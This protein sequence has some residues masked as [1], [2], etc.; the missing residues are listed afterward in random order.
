MDFREIG[1]EIVDLVHLVQDKEEWQ[2]SVN[3]IMNLWVL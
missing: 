3:V 2:V 1:W